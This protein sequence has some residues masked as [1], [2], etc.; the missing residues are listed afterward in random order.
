M[1]KEK[2]EKKAP[3]AQVEKKAEPKAPKVK[4]VSRMKVAYKDKV[5]PTLMKQFGYKNVMQVPK[6]DKVTINLGIGQATQNPKLVD[7]AVAELTSIV[8]QKVVITK[9]KKSISNFKLRSG[10]AIG[11]MATLRGNRMYMFLDKLFNIVLPRIRDFK[12]VSDKAFDGRG[13]YTL[14]LKE[15][16]LFPEINIDKVDKVIGMNICFTTT[17][18]SDNE[19]FHL[20]KTLGMPFRNASSNN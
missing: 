16:T 18:N 14:G 3:A 2:V 17:A 12:G 9:A 11:V 20:L 4:V 5:I 6:L 7:S 1:A 10:I 15:Q 19:A 13:N 8:G